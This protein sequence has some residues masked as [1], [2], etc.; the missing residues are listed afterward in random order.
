MIKI[1]RS[2][3]PPDIGVY[4]RVVTRGAGSRLTKAKREYIDALTFHANIAHYDNDVKL[5]KN[6]FTFSIYKDKE[7]SAELGRVF[8]NK[9]AYCESCFGA[10]TAKDIEHFRPKSEIETSD[11]MI[12]RPGYYWLAAEWMNLL[13]S[14]P[15]CNRKRT[16]RVPGQPEMVTLGKHIQ[17]PIANENARL[18][19]HTCSPVQIAAEEAQR[20]LINPC[21]ENPEDHFTYD[22]SGLIHPRN[23]NDNKAIFSIYVYALQRKGLVE[24]RKE[25]LVTLQ[26]RLLHLRIP[27]QELMEIASEDIRRQDAKQK[28]IA[29]L[30]DDVLTMFEPGKPYLGLLRDYIRKHNRSGTYRDYIFAGVNIGD[31][32]E[33][34]V[35]HQ[36]LR[37]QLA[38]GNL[39]LTRTR[40]APEMRRIS[41]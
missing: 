40:I 20:L 2:P 28:Q 41:P 36:M 16:H 39:G 18:R 30:M 21:I 19:M 17:F 29:D 1:N 24:A 13:V 8:G 9:C 10:V 26:R 35:S 3:V 23:A 27:I 38:Q 14:C 6:K 34:P 15:D 5:T 4:T 31:I 11:A 22:D 12:L 7:L 33:L 37:Q 25:T 32:L